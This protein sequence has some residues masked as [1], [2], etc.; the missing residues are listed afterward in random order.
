MLHQETLKD[1]IN[2]MSDEDISYALYGLILGDG[3]FRKGHRIYISHTGKQAFYTEWLDALFKERC[4]TKTFT[5][6]HDTTFGP[7][8]YYQVSILTPEGEIRNHEHFYLHD[9]KRTVSDHVLN[10]ISPLG[11]LFWYLDDGSLSVHNRGYSTCRF[12]Y[13]NTQAL[14]LD[15]NIRVA[16]MFEERFGIIVR[17]HKDHSQLS[18]DK[19][20]YRLYFSAT[21]FRQLYDLVRPYLK[22]IPD[23]FKYKFNM[24]YVPNRMSKSAEYAA[25]YNIA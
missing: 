6:T 12:A 21:A 5:Y 7:S 13:L 16:K 20:Y 1:I 24:K 10:N 4:Q 14:T 18:K 25:L 15:D 17:I 11:L 22:Y 23:D 8:T 19:V 2:T 3:R 9:G